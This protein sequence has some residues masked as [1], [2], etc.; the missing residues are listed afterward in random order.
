MTIAI[1]GER[2]L[3]P[4]ATERA[5]SQFWLEASRDLNFVWVPLFEY[6]VT[7]DKQYF[8][9]LEQEIINM[10]KWVLLSTKIDTLNKEVL[11][12]RI[13]YI[14]VEIKKIFLTEQSIY[15]G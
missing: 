14:L 3:I 6:G 7:I 10:Q 4:I 8:N 11:L 13:S 5:F 15:I 1:I 2:K 12:D 9:E